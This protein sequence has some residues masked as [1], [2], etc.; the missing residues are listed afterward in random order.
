MRPIFGTKVVGTSVTDVVL[1]HPYGSTVL[2]DLNA[3]I[4]TGFYDTN[5][6]GG[7]WSVQFGRYIFYRLY[8]DV[9]RY[10]TVTGT[11]ITFKSLSQ[12]VHNNR[13]EAAGMWILYSSGDWYLCVFY[14]GT[15]SNGLVARYNFTT[16]TW[17]EPSTAFYSHADGTHSQYRYQFGD[18]IYWFTSAGSCVA[19][20]LATMSSSTIT[21]SAETYTTTSMCVYNGV[22]HMLGHAGNGTDLALYQLVGTFQNVKTVVASLTTPGSYTQLFTDGTY[23]Y[24]LFYNNASWRCYQMDSAYNITDITTTVLPAY[25]R[26]G[27]LTSTSFRGWHIDA[28]LDPENPEIWLTYTTNPTTLAATLSWYRW[29]GPSAQMEYAGT[30]GE[31]GYDYWIGYDHAGGGQYAFSPGE[32]NVQI[33]GDITAGSAGNLVVPVRIYPSNNLPDDTLV[34]LKLDFKNGLTP[35]REYATLASVSPSG[36]LID[37]NTVR[38]GATSGT[39]YEVEWRASLDG[40]LSGDRVTITPRIAA[41]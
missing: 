33:E 30:A 29:R 41:A 26:A 7:P 3:T 40:I 28:H 13:E 19:M 11:T 20:N 27:S 21:G 1:I 32:P 16:D 38:V 23:L 39:L 22:I 12:Y 35:P 10:D 6:R 31:G 18:T 15:G 17:S 25:L 5:T 24:A 4:Q 8:G 2:F 9:K 36:T 37:S 34:D 14:P